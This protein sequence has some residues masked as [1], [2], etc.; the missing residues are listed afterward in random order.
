MISDLVIPAG[1]LISTDSLGS[2]GALADASSWL[3]AWLFELTLRST[4]LLTLAALLITLL[5]RARARVRVLILSS[6]APALLLLWVVLLPAWP[7]GSLQWRPEV[8]LP[9]AGFEALERIKVALGSE[10][11]RDS[12]P[13]AVPE[14]PLPSQREDSLISVPK[15]LDGQLVKPDEAPG[16]VRTGDFDASPS[17]VSSDGRGLLRTSSAC[18]SLC[19]PAASSFQAG[20][21]QRAALLWIGVLAVTICG[22]LWFMVRF[23]L[24]WR[25]LQ[26]IR[27]RASAPSRG[28]TRSFDRTLGEV[29]ATSAREH[30]MRSSPILLLS[31]EV[32]VPMTWGWTRPTV[33]LPS[34][35]SGWTESRRRVV[36]LHEIGHVVH[37]D[38]RDRLALALARSL[39]WWNP[40]VHWAVCRLSLEQELRCDEWVAERTPPS[41][42]AE[43][44]LS[45]HDDLHPL[46]GAAGTPALAMLNRTQLERRMMHLLEPRSSRSRN[47][48]P[49]KTQSRLRVL[50]VLLA[51][52]FLSIAAIR[53]RVVRVEPTVVPVEQLQP[54]ISV[55]PSVAPVPSNRQ[56]SGEVWPVLPRVAAAPLPPRA[57]S[58]ASPA[59]APAA[60]VLPTPRVFPAPSA[61]VALAPMPAPA[62]RALATFPTVPNVAP[63]ALPPLASFGSGPAAL[64]PVLAVQQPSIRSMSPEDRARYEEL[65]A[66]YD[67][68]RAEM[69]DLRAQERERSRE[70]R[71]EV[72]KVRRE[73]HERLAQ[74]ER[75][76]A[77]KQREVAA[78][79]AERERRAA[80][81]HALVQRETA[82]RRADLEREIEKVRRLEAEAMAQHR[83]RGSNAEPS[84][85]G[86]GQQA[87]E[88]LERLH[89][90]RAELLRRMEQVGSEHADRL[91]AERE[92]VYEV[93]K[94][95]LERQ[96]ALRREVLELQQQERKAE[97]A[98][99]QLAEQY[100][101][102]ALKRRLEAERM[103]RDAV[104][105]RREMER[106]AA[107]EARRSALVAPR[108]PSALYS[109]DGPLLQDGLR[110]VI[111][112]EA[113]GL[114][115]DEDDIE[116]GV[117]Q[118]ARVLGTRRVSDDRGAAVYVVG[119]PVQVREQLRRAWSH[120][121]DG[122]RG[123]E[124]GMRLEDAIQRLG[125]QILELELNDL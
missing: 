59:P 76:L 18:E 30:S 55:M 114:G 110:G 44:L 19:D 5:R 85:A 23:V 8:A 35:A 40:L 38:W 50:V 112:E 99:R 43:E 72:E 64:A 27:R 49:A 66:R 117:R 82:R 10:T 56:Q 34:S 1:L 45:L 26:G 73:H 103:E 51:V 32:D 47:E 121:L 41:H 21:A 69:E 53:P 101:M 96:Q 22:A 113:V 119:S 84:E 24:G 13:D 97:M 91:R 17:P 70:V 61:R 107:Q 28:F 14:L 11:V 88:A 3:P 108:A 86:S 29:L 60:A 122:E 33:V 102:T 92:A 31:S 123:S 15:Y 98:E 58:A 42:Y 111:R 106:L 39:F 104:R 78:T 125:S 36:L 100:E 118:A 2:A 115:L 63:A 95:A 90:E 75:E 81:E 7:E 62:P 52:A 94:E 116:A 20:P 83:R 16:S 67:E 77:R 9:D 79:M 37:G 105:V 65:K 68:I 87:A 46:A 89:L 48:S 74:R 71:S 54:E 6:M 4:V 12:Q 80:E 93:Q 124:Q 57:P 109:T 25:Q 120:L